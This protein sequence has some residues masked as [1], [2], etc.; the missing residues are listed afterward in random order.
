MSAG[1][2]NAQEDDPLSDVNVIPLADLSLVLLIVL[3]VLSPMIMQSMIKVQAS[4][5]TATRVLAKQP[6]EP[7]MILAI[8]SDGTVV[9]NAVKTTTDLDLAAR[10]AQEIGGRQ[11]KTVLL[12]ADPGVIHGRFVQILDL[13]KQQG[14]E[15]IALLK[16]AGGSAGPVWVQ[17]KKR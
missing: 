1:S 4:K 17:P 11:D 15:K 10:L 5:A 16:K 8:N 13:V 14:A 2:Q 12:T 7:P 6:L 3:M 9:L